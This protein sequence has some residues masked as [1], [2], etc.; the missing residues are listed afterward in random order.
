[1]VELNL[2]ALLGLA[3]Q[4]AFG[5]I[6]GR[7]LFAL[8][9]STGNVVRK[10]LFWLS[11]LILVLVYAYLTG[12][13]AKIIHTFDWVLGLGALMLVSSVAITFARCVSGAKSRQ[14]H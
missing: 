4:V 12:Q 14:E 11:G 9:S 8:Q 1:M 2:L 6:F 13:W 10:N 7:L 5:I 3:G